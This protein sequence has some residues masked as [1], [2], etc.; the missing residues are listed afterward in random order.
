MQPT[1]IEPMAITRLRSYARNARTHSK[2]QVRQIADSIQKFGFTN[3]I[4]ISDDGEIIAGHGRVEAAKLLGMSS[5]PTL[6]LSHLNAAQRRAYVIADN[7]LALNA[8]WDR[9]LLAVELQ[10]L[11]DLEF[12]VRSPASRCPRSNCCST[13]HGTR[14]RRTNRSSTR[15]TPPLPPAPQAPQPL[16]RR[17]RSSRLNRDQTRRPV[18][19]G[20]HGFSA[21]IPRLPTRLLACWRASVPT[22]CSPIPRATCRS[23][24]VGARSASAAASSPWASARCRGRPMRHSCKRRSKTRRHPA[25]RASSI[26]LPG[27]APHARAAR[28]WR[29]G[30][31]LAPAPLHLEQNQRRAG[32]TLSQQARVDLHISGRERSERGAHRRV[33][34]RRCRTRPR[35]RVGICA[36]CGL[37]GRAVRRRGTCRGRHRQTRRTGRRCARGLLEAGRHRA[38]SLCRFGHDADRRRRTGRRARLVEFDPAACEEI[39]RRYTHITG[40][41]ATL[42]AS[43]ESFDVVAAERA[44][45]THNAKEIVR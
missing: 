12:D 40:Q 8:G 38:R 19:P 22:W 16:L 37:A 29:S 3:P 30:I 23:R 5:V 10:A 34:G 18:G 41:A 26:R 17:N 15:R 42:A 45:F 13:K 24:G 39:V 27:L 9:E 31:L 33:R 28:R 20:E 6:R 14:S 36:G 35:R 32:T 11:I 2:K 44:R 21:A 43:G 4:L 25:A 7:K 1:T